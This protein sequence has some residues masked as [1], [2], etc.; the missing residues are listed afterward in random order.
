MERS[1]VTPERN[2]EEIERW[3]NLFWEDKVVSPKDN[4]SPEPGGSV[5]PRTA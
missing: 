1:T 4:F 2:Y 5:N 3:F